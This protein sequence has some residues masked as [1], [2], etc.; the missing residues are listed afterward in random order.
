[1]LARAAAV[2]A[3]RRR[4]LTAADAERRA[5]EQRLHDGPVASLRRLDRLLG[6]ADGQGTSE[7]RDELRAA[8]AEL[9][10]LGRGLFPPA[11]A[12]ADLSGAL[13]A[14]AHRSPVPAGVTITGDP[15]ALNDELTAATWFFCSEALANVARHAAA[16]QAAIMI[17]IDTNVLR[18][19]VRDNGQGGA[20]ATR[21]LRGLADRIEA[22]GG[23]LTITSP[24]GGP[25]SIL[26]ELP[27][28]PG[29]MPQT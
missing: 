12:R 19:E 16:T 21:G 3:S 17:R 29:T 2:R 8:I 5:L 25:T 1:V 20:T 28:H 6:A 4:L 26:A 11:L 15:R 24:T 9:T 23:S 22:G 7:L 13:E 18:I 14:I 27:L 10:D